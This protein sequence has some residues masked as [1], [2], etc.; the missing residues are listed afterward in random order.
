MTTQTKPGTPELS[1]EGHGSAAGVTTCLCPS[2]ADGTV[3]LHSLILP[4]DAGLGQQLAQPC[5]GFCP[6]VVVTSEQAAN[7]AKPREKCGGVGQRNHSEMLE[8]NISLGN[9]VL[10]SLSH[11]RGSKTQ[12]C[13]WI[14][15]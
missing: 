14:L 6:G 7:Q 8:D 5:Q 4:R 10:V 1:W 15:A 11:Y 2:A 13:T 9:T 3:P 12:V